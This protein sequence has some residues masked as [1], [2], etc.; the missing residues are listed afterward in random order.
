[1]DTIISDQNA[2][3]EPA[4][5]RGKAEACVS[6]SQVLEG[7]LSM[8]DPGTLRLGDAEVSGIFPP[9][10]RPDH[11]IIDPGTLRLGDAEV[12]VQMARL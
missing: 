9:L 3:Y 5:F 1:M 6:P 11:A 8:A 2:R 4:A 10:C 12:Y 7:A